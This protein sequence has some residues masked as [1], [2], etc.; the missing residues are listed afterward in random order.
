[1]LGSGHETT[2]ILED[3]SLSLA[4]EPEEQLLLLEHETRNCVSL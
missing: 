2:V 3:D 4:L 1:M